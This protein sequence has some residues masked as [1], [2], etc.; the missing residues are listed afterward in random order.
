VMYLG[1]VVEAGPRGEVFSDPRHPYTR[2]LLD[3]AP[4]LQPDAVAGPRLREEAPAAGVRPSGCSFHDRCPRVEDICR[5]DA[6]AL[7]PVEGHPERVAACHFSHEHR[8]GRTR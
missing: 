1:R 6:P 3:A 5:R 2:A 4:R 8:G 7:V